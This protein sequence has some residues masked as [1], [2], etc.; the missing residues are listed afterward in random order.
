[1]VQ[2]TA[3]PVLVPH[4]DFFNIFLPH[5]RHITHSVTSYCFEKL[6]N[7][8]TSREIFLVLNLQK[9]DINGITLHSVKVW[10]ITTVNVQVWRITDVI[11]HVGYTLL[12]WATGNQAL[13]DQQIQMKPHL[14]RFTR[15]REFYIGWYNDINFKIAPKVCGT[16]KNCYSWSCWRS[17]SLASSSWIPILLRW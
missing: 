6:P 17:R 16:L 4:I 15:G 14:F 11:F 7:E 9:I 3:R 12:T 10:I 2:D 8:E 5:I 13:I 1:M